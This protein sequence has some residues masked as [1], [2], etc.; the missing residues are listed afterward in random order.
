[1]ERRISLFFPLVL[2][3]AG[4][5]WIMIQM[6]SIQPSSLW[7]LFYLWP[8]LLITVGLGLILRAYWRY[9]TLVFDFLVVGGAFLAVLFAPQLGWTHAPNYVITGNGF[10]IGPGERG[11]GKIITETRQVQDFTKMR[12]T[13]PAQVIISQGGSESI[14]IEADDNVAAEIRTQVINGVLDIDPLHDHLLTISPTRPP[15]ITI[16]VKDLTELDFESAGD[17]QLN[18]LTTDHLKM[19]MDGAGSVKLNKVQ[20][21]SLECNLNGV[22]S[23]E[24][25]GTTDAIN[26]HV[27]G[28]GSFNGSDL[29]SQAATVNLDGMG[30]ATVWADSNLKADVSGMGS[31]NYYGNAQ[32]SK[33]VDGLGSV[34]YLGNK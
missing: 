6:K 3:A 30:S 21:K 27:Q 2:I 20:L 7:A 24:A 10:F 4:S 14:T 23:V 1:M 32:V 34:K 9:S 17:V 13:Y 8:F 31:V 22:G 18:G 15:K 19:I 25:S 5:V 29:H 12:I 33:T 28:L 26:V 16:V 11:S